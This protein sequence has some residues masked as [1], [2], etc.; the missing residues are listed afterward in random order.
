MTLQE[1]RERAQA[2]FNKKEEAQREGQKAMQEYRAN[3]EAQRD[4]DGSLKALRLARKEAN[5]E[6]GVK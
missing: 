1:A 3:V 2:L 6:K 4:K 5:E